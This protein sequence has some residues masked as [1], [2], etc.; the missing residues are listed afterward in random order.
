MEGAA[1]RDDA[2]PSRHAARELEGSLNRLRA[3]VAEE[4]R[5][6]RI[7]AGLGQHRRETPHRFEISQGIADVEELVRLVLDRGGHG[8][9][10]VTKRRGGDAARKIQKAPALG[11]IEGVALSVAPVALV[12]ASQDRGE[13][14]LRYSRVVSGDCQRVDVRRG[15]V[16]GRCADG[17]GG[18]GWDR[19]ILG[20]IHDERSSAR[21]G[22]PV[23]T[24]GG[25]SRV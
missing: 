25:V 10:V 23:D 3:G 1:E 7:R 5:I 17:E 16:A 19:L 6:Q 4:D 15:E 12:V 14:R 11:V 2:G 24:T 13:I 20:G 21:I 8:R 22:S 9:M 18:G